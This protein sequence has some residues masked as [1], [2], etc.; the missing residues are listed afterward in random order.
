LLPLSHCSR[1]AAK[2]LPLVFDDA[3]RFE[4]EGQGHGVE[5]VDFFATNVDATRF[6][7]VRAQS[8]GPDLVHYFREDGHYIAVIETEHSVQVHRR[9]R[10]GQTG[11][12]HFLHPLV[13]EQ[14][15]R[16]L[17]DGLVRRSFA[18]ADQYHTVTDGHHVTAFQGGAAVLLI[19]V[20][21][22]DLAIW[23][24]HGVNEGRRT[25]LQA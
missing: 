19:R 22:P 9:A 15:D 11:D 8:E 23:H 20:A 14:V 17:A 24:T 16:Q 4:I 12:N 21:I 7:F 5:E 25:S 2:L 13:L 10:F 1:S 18:H 6:A 3:Q